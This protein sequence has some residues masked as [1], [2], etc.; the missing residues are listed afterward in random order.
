VNDEPTVDE[1]KE[2][3]KVNIVIEEEE[4]SETK[5]GPQED[6]SEALR[7]LGRQFAET[8]QAAWDSQERREF[9]SEV[10]EGVQDFAEEVSK[11]FREARESRAA[12]KVKEEAEE[13]KSRVD[14]G[15]LPRKARSGLVEGLEWL[16]NELA[17]L[18]EQFSPPQAESQE[19]DEEVEIDIKVE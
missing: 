3:E 17:R 15:E 13:V 4:V 18:A 14:A 16:S 1:L 10:R 7:D 9:E 11:V 6:V 2:E 12:K 5:S 19:T 8:I